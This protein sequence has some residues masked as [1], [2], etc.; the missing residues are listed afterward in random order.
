[1]RVEQGERPPKAAPLAVLLQQVAEQVDVP[2]LAE[3]EY[4]PKKPG[5]SNRQ[6]WLAA[7]IVDEPLTRALDLL[8]ADFEY[9]WRFSEGMLLLRP[10]LWFAQEKERQYVVPE[11]K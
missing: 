5:W 4:E 11:P 6:W 8:C 1:M 9:E 3:C 7:D 10:R 2:I